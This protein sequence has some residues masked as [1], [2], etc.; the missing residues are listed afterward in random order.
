LTDA[1]RDAAR[2]SNDYVLDVFKMGLSD[3]QNLNRLKDKM[4]Q[5]NHNINKAISAHNA[6]SK[7]KID[8]WFKIKNLRPTTATIAMD[9]TKDITFV[10]E[11]LVHSNLETT[12]RYMK[13]KPTDTKRKNQLAYSKALKKVEKKSSKL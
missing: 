9:S 2:K 1:E 10:Q 13:N 3:E 7:K 8:L 12:D 4:K 11:T 5:I 6:T